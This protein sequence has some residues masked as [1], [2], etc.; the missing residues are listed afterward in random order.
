MNYEKYSEILQWHKGIDLFDYNPTIDWAIELI[1][2]GIE[3]ENVLILAS[4][5]KP[6]DRDEIKP[7]VTGALKDLNLIEKYGEYSI[8]A[9]AHY[10]LDQILNDYNIRTNLY[11]VYELYLDT[12]HDERLTPFFLLYHGWNEL[13]E[14]GVNLY[15]EGANLKNI[16]QVLKHQAQ[17]WIN[18]YVHGVEIEEEKE[19]SIKPNAK[20]SN[21]KGLKSRNSIWHIIKRLWQQL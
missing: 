7:Y 14:I 21:I 13:E 17:I 12:D 6:V 9:N 11:K 2:Q 18:K 16:E 3:T 5:S 15:F 19:E 8:V 1:K 4:F 10:Y 20:K